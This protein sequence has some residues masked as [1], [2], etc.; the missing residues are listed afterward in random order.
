MYIYR[1]IYQSEGVPSGL[2]YSWLRWVWGLWF[3]ISLFVVCCLSVVCLFPGGSSATHPGDAPLA[4]PAGDPPGDPP[5][6]PTGDPP[7]DPPSD[8]P[9]S[10]ARIAIWRVQGIYTCIYMFN[11]QG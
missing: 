8:P 5:G 4:T 9:L 1:Y 6:D 3:D 10:L 2:F 11:I 7:G